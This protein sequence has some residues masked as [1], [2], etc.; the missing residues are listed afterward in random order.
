MRVGHL[1]HPKVMHSVFAVALNDY[2]Q[3]N[4]NRDKRIEE[5]KR[6]IKEN[7]RQKN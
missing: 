6:N 1:G 3:N 2:G 7:Q 5:R 4:L